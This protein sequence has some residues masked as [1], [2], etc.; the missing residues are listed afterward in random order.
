MRASE[1]RKTQ[2]MHIVSIWLRL[3]ILR[4]LTTI[5]DFR[6]IVKPNENKNKTKNTHITHTPHNT[7]YISLTYIDILTIWNLF[8]NLLAKHTHTHTLKHFNNNNKH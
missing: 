6:R 2:A 5:V 3:T 7:H 1:Y 8:P 4:R